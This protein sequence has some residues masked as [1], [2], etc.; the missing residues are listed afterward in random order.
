MKIAQ[1]LSLHFV[2]AIHFD[3]QKYSEA[4][5]LLDEMEARFPSSLTKFSITYNNDKCL[6]TESEKEIYVDSRLR[7]WVSKY[8]KM[9]LSVQYAQNNSQKRM[10]YTPLMHTCLLNEVASKNCGY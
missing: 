2:E 9:E 8:P 5:K 10:Y 1:A 6:L 4:T 7:N 3:I